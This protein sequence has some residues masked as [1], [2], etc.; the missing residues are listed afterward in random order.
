MTI[1]PKDV[2]QLTL[3]VNSFVKDEDISPYIKQI[4]HHKGLLTTENRKKYE[5]FLEYMEKQNG[6]AT[7]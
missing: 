5:N 3:W 6:I 1:D 7:K 2:E 4:E